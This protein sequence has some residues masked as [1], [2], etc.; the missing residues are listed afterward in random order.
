MST[1]QSQ[2]TPEIE[3]LAGLE[4]RR[5]QALMKTNVEQLRQLLAPELM[6]IHASGRIDAFDE[7]IRFASETV[8]F[9]DVR[10]G[11]LTIRLHGDTAVMMGPQSVT[12]RRKTE[13][14]A[15]TMQTQVIQVW[16]RRDAG[17]QQAYF[18]AT[19]FAKPTGSAT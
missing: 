18:Q 6:H 12:F 7:F 13:Q 1:P 3:L 2:N 4:A 14:A 19:P 10:R 16:I 15:K 9:E 8:V 5:C 11:E 17:W